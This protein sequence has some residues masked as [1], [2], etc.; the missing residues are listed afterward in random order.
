MS[1]LPLKE[2]KGLHIRK[3]LAVFITMWSMPQGLPSLLNK[4]AL[5]HQSLQHKGHPSSKT[6]VRKN[7]DPS[8]PQ[9]ATVLILLWSMESYKLVTNFPDK[10]ELHKMNWNRLEVHTRE[11]SCS[12]EISLRLAELRY[13][14]LICQCW[15][16]P[17]ARSQ[18]KYTLQPVSVVPELSAM[19]VFR[20]KPPDLILIISENQNQII[21]V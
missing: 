10:T 18:E 17:E 20:V 1:L 11:L 9:K 19:A 3:A 4:Q 13:Q 2:A 14:P 6:T 5:G 16:L 7:A 15:T 8:A 21:L 12:W